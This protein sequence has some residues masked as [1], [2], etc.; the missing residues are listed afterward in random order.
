VNQCVSGRNQDTY[1]WDK[2]RLPEFGPQSGNSDIFIT[3]LLFKNYKPIA[4]LKDLTH[5]QFNCAVY[6][7]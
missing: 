6:H 5:D 2:I 4:I 7:V 1:I 3:L